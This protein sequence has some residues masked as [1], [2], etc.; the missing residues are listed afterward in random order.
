M[1][2][3]KADDDA[4]LKEAKERFTRCVTWETAWRDR[5]LFDTKFANG[6]PLNQWQWDTTVRTD[7]GSRP[8]L[9]Y[10]QVRQHNLQVINDARQNKAQIKIT[11]TGG[12]ASYEAAQVFSG[13]IRRIEYVSKAV[14]AYSTATYHQVESGIGY[15]RVET[16]YVDEKS[17]EL[18][19]FIRRVADP[20]TIYMDPDCKQYDKSDAAFAFVFE[21]VPRDRYEEEY[22]TEEN[23]AP[24]TTLDHSDGWNDKDHVRI[25]EYWRRG[26]KNSK[27]HRL[28]DGTVVR[29]DDIP[30]DLRDQVEGMIVKS[31]EVAEPEIEW[32]KLAGD[33]IIDREDWPG[34]YIPIVPFLGEETVID[35]EM[36]RKGHTRAQIDAQRIYNYWASAAVEQVALQTKTPY[37]ARV[38][39]ITGREEQWATA[40]TKNWSV[41]VYNGVDESGNPIPPPARSPP[42]EMAQAYIQ[43]MTIARQDLMSVTGQYQAELGMPSN[44]RSGIAIQQ[45]QRQGDTATYH[46]IDNQAK[47]IRQVGRILIDLIPK[48]YDTARVVKIMAEDGSDADVAVVPDAAQAH[49]HVQPQPQPDGSVAAV[50]LSPEQAKQA[51]EDPNQPDPRIIF[52]P[53]IGTY[54]V[55]ADV[56]PAYGTQRQ[57]AANAFSQIMQQNPAAFQIVGDFWAA[58]SDFPGA[59]ELADRLKRGLPPQ[60]KSGIDPQV[61]QISQQAQQMHQQAQQFLAKADQ[62]IIQLKQENRELKLQLKDKSVS[63]VIDD[64]DAE[65]RRLAAVGNIDP[66]SLQIVVRQLVEDMWATK[67]E[68]MLH[69]HADIQGE[70]AQRMAPPQPMNG[71]GANGGAGNGADGG[72]GNGGGNGA[73]PAQPPP[74]VPPMPTAGAGQTPPP[75]QWTQQQ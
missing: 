70:V 36:D 11:P 20:R 27:I 71:N 61:Q 41:L 16:D 42:P 50:P 10:N 55:E 24:T 38:D 60:Y 26:V 7:R 35:G 74:A 40:N 5:A 68:P 67:L 3:A 1:P 44:E 59:D 75:M 62:E 29:D 21:D 66:H 45:R 43:G 69:R 54:D 34:K 53:N 73:A 39:A 33:K 9:S 6:D 8:C 13:I 2:R 63:H 22:G 23:P 57:E 64:Y 14:D 51:Q 30:D 37:V 15:V 49:Q 18:D 56:G 4:I 46:Y 72:D 48:V 12:R 58:N 52:N 17:F 65:T 28:S 19:L 47:A 31:R 25:A 32:F